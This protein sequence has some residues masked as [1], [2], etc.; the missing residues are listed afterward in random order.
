[1]YYYYI[2]RGIETSWACMYVAGVQT[3]AQQKK[4]IV[5][6]RELSSPN[7]VVF[8]EQVSVCSDGISS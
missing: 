2:I 4:D 5:V 1:M 7:Y 8:E 3:L 6:D